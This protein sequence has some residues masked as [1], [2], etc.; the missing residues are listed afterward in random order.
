MCVSGS[1]AIFLYAIHPGKGETN[2]GQVFHWH[3]DV[4]VY[5]DKNCGTLNGHA[6]SCSTGQFTHD[7]EDSCEV[8]EHHPVGKSHKC[9][10]TVPDTSIEMLARELEIWAVPED[11]RHGH[12]E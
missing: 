11:P 5:G 9:T 4:G 8:A 1:G 12:K 10:H 6:A 2:M 3:A 7:N